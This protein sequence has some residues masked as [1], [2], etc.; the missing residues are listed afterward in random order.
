M[1]G[2]IITFMIRIILEDSVVRGV[3]H[4]QVA[5]ERSPHYKSVYFAI[6]SCEDMAI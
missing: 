3:C 1:L 4:I 2:G 5:L 6:S